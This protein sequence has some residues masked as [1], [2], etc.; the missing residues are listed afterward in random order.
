MTWHWLNLEFWSMVVQYHSSSR[1]Q[2]QGTTASDCI[3]RWHL[4]LV[5]S[6]CSDPQTSGSST[7]WPLESRHMRRWLVWMAVRYLLLIYS[8]HNVSELNAL[9]WSCVHLPMSYISK[10]S[11]SS[12]IVSILYRLMDISKTIEQIAFKLSIDGRLRYFYSII[13]KFKEHSI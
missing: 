1:P 10:T 8:L 12:G 11:S 4:F 7:T 5:I 2:R 6:M 9:W 13:R 3:M